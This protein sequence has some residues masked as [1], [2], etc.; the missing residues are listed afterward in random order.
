MFRIHGWLIIGMSR[1][2]Y[3]NEIALAEPQSID[4]PKII[5]SPLAQE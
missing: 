2:T 4:D 3:A 5:H 1:V